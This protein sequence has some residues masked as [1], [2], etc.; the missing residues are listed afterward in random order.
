MIY[1]YS[2]KLQ[3]LKHDPISWR[4]LLLPGLTLLFDY[5]HST[6]N[7]IDNASSHV[8]LVSISSYEYNKYP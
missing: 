5:H 1:T 8:M 7:T 2:L 6:L 4:V 3:S